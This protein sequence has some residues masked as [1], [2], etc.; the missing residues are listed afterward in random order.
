M[1]KIKGD[2]PI[3]VIIHLYIEVATFISNKQKCHFFL[4][5]SIKLENRKVEQLLPCGGEG[6]SVGGRR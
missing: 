4:F 3:G 5:L 1:K 6:E 2:K